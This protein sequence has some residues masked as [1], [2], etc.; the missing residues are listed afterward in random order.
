MTGASDPVFIYYPSTFILVINKLVFVNASYEFMLTA[1][2]GFPYPKETWFG[3]GKDSN[4]RFVSGFTANYSPRV[5]FMRFN[6]Y[7]AKW[8][9]YQTILIDPEMRGE[10]YQ[11][12]VSE[13]YVESKIIPGEINKTLVCTTDS[14]GPSFI[15][16][17]D[18]LERHSQRPPLKI[19]LRDHQIRLFEFRRR[20]LDQSLQEQP[21]SRK[22]IK[23]L[24]R[25]NNE[26]MR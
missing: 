12:L 3:K 1:R 23:M 8:S 7:P 10:E 22:I 9:S 2:M 25:Y 11:R 15:A 26:G 18:C 17:G 16:P 5:P 13:K 21:D 6:F 4:K 14:G 20:L 19:G 24:K